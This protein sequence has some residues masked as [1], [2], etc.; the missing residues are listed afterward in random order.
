MLRIVNKMGVGV[1]CG[2]EVVELTGEPG[3]KESEEEAIE[4]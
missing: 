4:T 3:A 2:W 1:D